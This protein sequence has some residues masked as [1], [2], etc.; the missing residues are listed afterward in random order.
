M[1]WTPKPPTT[2]TA[3]SLRA[4]AVIGVAAGLLAGLFGV[5]G[6]IIMVPAMVAVGVG[7]HRAHA[8]SLLAILV[9]AL[10]GVARFAGSGEV[11]WAIG[12][13]VA[14]GAVAG[15]TLGSK[16]MGRMSP[17]L[18]RGVF[19]FL[20]VGAGV[21]MAMGGEVIGGVD[22]EGMVAWLLALLIGLAAGFAAGIAGVGGGVIIVPALVFLLGVEQHRAEGTSL[23]VIVFTA[24]AATRVNLTAGRMNLREGL[25]MGGAGV[26][27]TVVGA[28]VALEMEPAMLTRIFGIFVL[29]VAARLAWSLRDRADRADV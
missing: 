1:P 3:A 29:V 24:L 17:Q 19:V 14:M 12:A 11:D 10:A 2:D 20:L 27:S 13:A 4:F 8:T 15:S 5:G 28:S 26:V 23:M 22:L 18:L 25:T 21:R 16:T 9:I 6:G 7:Q